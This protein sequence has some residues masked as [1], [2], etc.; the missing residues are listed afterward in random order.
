MSSISSTTPNR[1]ELS[2]QYKSQQAEKKELEAT[3]TSE[4]DN[5]KNSYAVEKADT[6]DRFETSIQAE[7]GAHYD[8]LRNLKS[9]LNREQRVLEHQRDETVT[10]KSSQLKTDE[11][12][13]ERDGR[14]RIN[15]VVRKYA[16]AEAYERKRMLE[17]ESEI[18]TDHKKSAELIIGD[19]QKRLNKLA[20]EK[21]AYLE[22]QKET[23]ATAIGQ[24]E[25]H[26]QDLRGNLEK[27]HAGELSNLENRTK[28][29]LNDRKIASATLIQNFDTPMKDPFYGIKRFE[30]DLLDQGDAYILRVKVPEY[31]RKQFKVQVAG[32][33]IQLTGVRTNDQK[34]EI[35]PG[36]TAATRSYQN[37]TERYA[38]A[39]PV[40]GRSMVYKEDGEWLEYTL[41]KF[42]ENHRVSDQF[43]KPLAYEEDKALAKDL[44]FK[45]TLPRPAS[46]KGDAG[47]GTMA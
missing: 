21:A 43:R 36:R 44:E 26:F 12:R 38:L 31:E 47:S 35:E 2:E 13:T 46:V 28:T 3:H 22:G 45:N 25:H 24:M 19:S 42:G 33:E 8:H 6:E 11:I 18:R 27:Q 16:E 37:V 40:D 7:K 30:S 15:E 9:Q 32:Q 20:E 29:E 23:H 41:P 4:M 10:Q 34:V 17:A 39:S 5:L 1:A 14:A